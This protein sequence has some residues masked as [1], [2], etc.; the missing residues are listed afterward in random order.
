MNPVSNVR[1]LGV[2]PGTRVAGWAVVRKHGRSFQLIA[3]GAVRAPG[4]LA[5][6]R[7]AT[8]HAGLLQVARTHAADEA[9]VEEVFAGRNLKAALAVGQGRGVA[10]AALGALDLAVY[11][12]P[13]RVIKRAVTGNGAA[14]KEQVAR[15]VALQLGL[16]KPP[17]PADIT[18]ACA[19]AMTHL[20]RREMPQVDAI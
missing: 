15:M 3:C 4:H 7:L 6:K 5:E 10:L 8:I 2:D 1:V 13:A 19:V 16:P 12:Y 18:D 9:A 20:I 14:S 17:E 11:S